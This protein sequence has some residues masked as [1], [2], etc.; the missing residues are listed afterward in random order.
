MIRRSR[1]S[2]PAT[3]VALLGL[4]ICALVAT[5][6]IQLLLHKPPVLD[7]ARAAR[8]LHDTQWHELPVVIGGAILGVLGLALLLSAVL[9]GRALVLP[10]Q[11]GRSTS[12]PLI[13]GA[14]SR[15]MGAVLRS[16]G[17]SVEGVG[18]VQ[19]KLGRKKVKAK[20]TA[21]R[22]AP[23]D[24]ADRVHAALEGQLDRIAPDTRPR[25]RVKIRRS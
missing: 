16:A 9:P 2:L 5:S 12:D 18:A 23:E 1:R 20:V 24:L 14:R 8:A 17:E 22:L 25:T 13:S 19:V 6:A 7:Y 21:G 10:L 11:G 4:V 3:V 15:S